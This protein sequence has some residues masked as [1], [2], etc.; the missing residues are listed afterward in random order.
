[1]NKP[2]NRVE[3]DIWY[4]SSNDR[5]LDFIRDFGEWDEKFGTNVLMEPHYVFWQCENCDDDIKNKDCFGG[6]KYCAYESSNPKI[7]G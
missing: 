7:I 5:A 3:Y 4:T 2:D 1:M 6:G